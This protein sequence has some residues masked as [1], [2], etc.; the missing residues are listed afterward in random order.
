MNH[1]NKRTN[2]EVSGEDSSAKRQEDNNKKVNKP[3]RKPIETEPANKR[4]AQNRA[5]QRAFRERKERKMKELEDRINELENEKKSA[6]TETEF[7]RFQVQTLINELSKHRPIN[8]LQQL[9]NQLPQMP[10]LP[11]GSTNLNNFQTNLNI[12]NHSSDSTPPSLLSS[13]TTPTSISDNNVH[14]SANSNKQNFSFEFPWSSRKSSASASASGSNPNS[15]SRLNI[16][17]YDKVAAPALSSDGSSTTGS[18]ESSPFELYNTEEQKDLPLF[19][20]VKSTFPSTMNSAHNSTSNELKFDDK[21]D[22]RISDFC[23]NLNSACGTKDCPVPKKKSS[24]DLAN[25]NNNTNQIKYINTPTDPLSFLNEDSFQAFD[26][27]LAFPNEFNIN[28]NNTNNNGSNFNL[29]DEELDQPATSSATDPLEGLV[30][31]E[32]I[33]DPFGLFSSQGKSPIVESVQPM[34][35]Q[36]I[37][38][39]PVAEAAADTQS[40]TATEQ[41][42]TDEDVVPSRDGRL[43]KCTEIWD[44]ITS[45]PKYSEIDIDGLC[46]ELRTKAKCSDK[47]VVI[48]CADV[49]KVLLRNIKN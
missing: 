31:E 33:Y 8:D 24:T 7:L 21:F 47:G 42:Q 38:L 5:A 11:N 20:K 37:P 22:E 13:G 30:T 46:G 48:D 10:Q 26:P 41:Q 49:N 34:A 23:S 43:L 18:S 44:R 9:A 36:D 17:N 39:A 25:D 19:H 12:E 29:F 14:S 28:I 4:A 45:H 40:A 35:K 2:S 16:Q 1:E 3:G 6:T 27:S 32:S 15:N